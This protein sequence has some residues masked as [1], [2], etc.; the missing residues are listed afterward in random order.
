MIPRKDIGWRGYLIHLA[1]L[2]VLGSYG[3]TRLATSDKITY[4]YHTQFE[5]RID[6]LENVVSLVP[7]INGKLDLLL[8]LNGISKK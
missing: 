5:S 7:I 6:Q 8:E 3:F 1:I 2:L 4:K